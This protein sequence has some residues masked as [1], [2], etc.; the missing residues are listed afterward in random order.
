MT[1]WQAI[2]LGLLQGATEFIPVSSSGHL[3][4]VPWLLGW[5][6]PGL[7]FSLA[8]HVG[9]ALAVLA[10]FYQDWIAMAS[11]TIMWIRERKPISGQAKLLAL[12]IV[13]TIPA[14]V[15][16]LMFEDFFERIFQSPLVGAIMLSV[17]AL[18]LYAG[19]RL[20]ELTRKLNDLDW[21]DA[22]F[23]G[24]AQALAIFPGISRSGAT[25]AAGRSR[26]I[27]RDAA[28]KF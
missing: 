18:L 22:I 27:E 2:L 21:A 20:G 5:D 14:G 8:V 9:T 28:A 25:I 26:N 6:P 19:E 15:I 1:I 4:L 24:F 13:G 7:T 11:S 23:I 3:L 16:G 12:L 10:Y 17:T